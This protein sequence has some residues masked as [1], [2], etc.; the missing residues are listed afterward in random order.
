MTDT[1]DALTDA[2]TRLLMP[3][4]DGEQISAFIE[5]LRAAFF[6]REIYWVASEGWALMV[7]LLGLEEPPRPPGTDYSMLVVLTT[8]KAGDLTPRLLAR[9]APHGHWI[10]WLEEDPIR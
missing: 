1:R 5:L 10:Q 4:L 8:V 2:R 6:E 7:P 3:Y 9:A